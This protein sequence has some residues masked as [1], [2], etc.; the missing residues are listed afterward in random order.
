MFVVGLTGGI[1]S[2]KTTVAQLFSE[3]NVE[4]ID[5]DEIAHDLVQPGQPAL[6]ELQKATEEDILFADGQLNR[7]L[8]RDL[9]FS[10]SD[11]KSIV[12]KILHPKIREITANKISDCRKRSEVDYIVLVIPLLVDNGN[13]MMIDRILVVD[14]EDEKQ[15]ER[16]MLRDK[17]TREQVIAVMDAQ[18][19][20]EERL[21]AADDVIDNNGDPELLEEM[22]FSLNRKYLELAKNYQQSD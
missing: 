5:T 19:D 14:C 20:R 15:I 3:L 10:N 9:L 6:E 8:L 16:V 12:E 4:I 11:I 1:G 22:V 21:L 7:R 13:W 17:Q 2:G 18:I